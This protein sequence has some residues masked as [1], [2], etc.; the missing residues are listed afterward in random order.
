MPMAKLEE[1]V[2]G[3]LREEVEAAYPKTTP[4]EHQVSLCMELK[5]RAQQIRK[6]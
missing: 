6:Y 3:G 1:I 4:R 2:R 5:T